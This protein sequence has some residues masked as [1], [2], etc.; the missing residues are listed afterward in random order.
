[1]DRFSVPLWPADLSVRLPIV[2]PV[3]LYPTALLIGREL[4]YEQV[5][6]PFDTYTMRY[7]YF[8]RAYRTF[9]SAIPLSQPDSS[10]VTHPSATMLVVRRQLLL[11][12]TCD[13][14]HRFLFPTNNYCLTTNTV[15]LECV[16]HAASVH[17]E[18]G[19]NSSFNLC[20]IS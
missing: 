3:G 19:S 6:L 9:P 20:S 7:I 16:M 4:I 10:R 15:R 13:A 1:M 2:A 17:P 12:S 14:Y 11:F 18:P 8:M 5:F